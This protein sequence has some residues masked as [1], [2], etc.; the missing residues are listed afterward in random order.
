MKSWCCFFCT[1]FCTENCSLTGCFFVLIIFM[2]TICVKK[3]KEKR[4]DNMKLFILSERE[5]EWYHQRI[6]DRNRIWWLRNLNEDNMPYSVGMGNQVWYFAT[7]EDLG[8]MN[9]VYPVICLD[10]KK[11]D[12]PENTVKIGKIR[13]RE[14]EWE[15]LD[16]KSGLC[17]SKEP[18]FQSIFSEKS[19]CEYPESEIARKLGNIETYIFS[20]QE[21]ELILDVDLEKGDFIGEDVIDRF[22]IL[23]STEY[24]RYKKKIKCRNAW[25]RNDKENSSVYV[26]DSG[27]MNFTTEFAENKTEKNVIPVMR[28]DSEE[29]KNFP[30]F[31]SSDR[32][33]YGKYGDENIIWKILD[34]KRGL[35]IAEN[36]KLLIPW[37]PWEKAVDYAD[38]LVRAYMLSMEEL[39]LI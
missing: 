15:I 30:K 3:I 37:S 39:I 31:K 8:E 9:W 36:L 2:Y 17:I 20:V 11:F 33:R 29:L 6:G 25:L 35:C 1:F 13:T 23:S 21:L 32:I 5:F 38:S 24:E 26:D 27:I 10:T 12:L 14:I 28:W 7:R 18:F 19:G 22:S 34:A 16:R 4:R